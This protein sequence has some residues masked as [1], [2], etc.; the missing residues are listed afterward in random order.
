MK[1]NFA[2]SDKI[3]YTVVSFFYN[4]ENNEGIYCIHL[5]YNLLFYQTIRVWVLFACLYYIYT[6]IDFYIFILIFTVYMDWY[7]IVIDMTMPK[8][9]KIQVGVYN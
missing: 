9:I 2:I 8:C 3:V 1:C 4:G 6:Y 5:P 7:N